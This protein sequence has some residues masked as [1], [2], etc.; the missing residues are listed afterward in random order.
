MITLHT[1]KLSGFRSFQAEQTFTFPQQ[2]GFYLLSGRNKHAPELGA[3][4]AGK[5]SLW[6]GLCWVLYGKTERD[7]RS[8]DIA[9]W[10]GT[11]LTQGTLSLS[12]GDRTYTLRRSHK[13]NSLTMQWGHKEPRVISQDK[14]DAF[15]GRNW[16]GFIGTVLMG[17]FNRFFFDLSPTERLDVFSNALGL[18]YWVERADKAKQHAKKAAEQVQRLQQDSAAN[19]A[20]VVA[21]AEQQ[22]TWANLLLTYTNDQKQKA[23]DIAA[24]LAEL[25]PG[26]DKL[27]TKID[28][29]EYRIET[30]QKEIDL[31]KDHLKK[32]HKTENELINCGKDRDREQKAAQDKYDDAEH[33]EQVLE[34]TPDKCAACGQPISPEH[35]LAEVAK[36]KRRKANAKMLM[37]VIKDVR[38]KE[39]KEWYDN[40]DD[41]KRTQTRL[42]CREQE[43]RGFERELQ[44]YKNNR[45]S[46]AHEVEHLRRDQQDLQDSYNPY[47]EQIEQGQRKLDKAHFLYYDTLAKLQETQAKQRGYEQWAVLFKELRLWLIETAVA[48]LQV[49]INN[50]LPLL[51]LQGWEITCVVE[52]PTKA[53]SVQRGFNILVANDRTGNRPVPWKAWSGGETQRLRIAGARGLQALVDDRQGKAFN[54]EVWDEPT[55][56]L[57]EAGIA[58]LLDFLGTRARDDMQ[59]VWLVDHRTLKAGDFDGEARIVYTEHGSTIRNLDNG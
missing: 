42:T 28:Q 47:P 7:L 29:Y 2:A 57:S 30:W 11:D 27:T 52:K 31:H 10:E 21:I 40:Q 49:E 35:L 43:L 3:N 32:L 18:D 36:C 23:R 22:T 53:G 46:I 25:V 45:S 39:D 56:F 13:P 16:E 12:K 48:Q 55:A 8:T 26:F 58:S 19:E 1:L 34:K 9:N 44:G 14:L 37:D 59:Q 50:A 38:R 51:G 5:S 54:L 15:L 17:Q 6:S 4:G 20:R 33:D 24:Q 41:I